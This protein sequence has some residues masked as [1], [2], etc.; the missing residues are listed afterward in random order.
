[1][2][3]VAAHWLLDNPNV[4]GLSTSQVSSFQ[5]G[6][7]PGSGVSLLTE[8]V[9]SAGWDRAWIDG[10]VRSILK[11]DR[12]TNVEECGRVVSILCCV[13]FVWPLAQ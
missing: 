8:V 1:M 12:K 4:A 11:S 7:G 9:P 6:C 3:L 13:Q 5:G 10:I 2:L